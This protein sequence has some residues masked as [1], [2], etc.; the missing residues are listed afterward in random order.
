MCVLL[1]WR[2]KTAALRHIW[3]VRFLIATLLALALTLLPVSGVAMASSMAQAP[4]CHEM[5]GDTP[6]PD[7]PM[8]SDTG[9]ACAEHCMM[10]VSAPQTLGGTSAPS[11]ANVIAAEHALLID[12]RAPRAADPPDTPPPRS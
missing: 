5:G 6:M 4:S 9:A 8:K 10:Q 3:T 7:H 11:I 12:N 1:R 2:D